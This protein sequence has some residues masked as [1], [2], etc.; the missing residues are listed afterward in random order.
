[1]LGIASIPSSTRA[2]ERAS[3]GVERQALGSAPEGFLTANIG[4]YSTGSMSSQ[5]KSLE[6]SVK[7]LMTLFKLQAAMTTIRAAI[8][9]D[10][11]SGGGKLYPARIPPKHPPE[12]PKADEE[13]VESQKMVIY[14]PIMKAD[15]ERRE[16]TGV[17]LQPEVTDAQGDIISEAVIEK[18]A[19]DFLASFNKSTKL[20]LMHKEFNKN[21][22]L[23][24]SYVTPSDMVIANKTVRKGA[25]VM[26]VRV[27]DDR[28]WKAV[29][30]GKI[31]GF[32]IG[33]KAKAQ[34][35]AA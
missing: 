25:W 3:Q 24:Q 18:A 5:I 35:L 2:R 13:D 20:G 22:E 34:K 4:A 26:V 16:V 1:L 9:A 17:V 11:L 6:R 12:P 32:S 14:I 7:A 31:T 23:R 21:F 19:G 29:K 30:D 10:S 28:I 15:D 27:V 33:G 8:G